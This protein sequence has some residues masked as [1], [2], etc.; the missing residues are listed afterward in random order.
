MKIKI[1]VTPTASHIQ[2]SLVNEQ[3]ASD[4]VLTHY[5][6]TDYR[7]CGLQLALFH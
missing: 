1:Q 6:T 5:Q 3:K 4:Q 7:S 2:L